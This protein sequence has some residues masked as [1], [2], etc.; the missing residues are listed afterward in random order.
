MGADEPVRVEVD[1]GLVTIV[2]DQPPIN[3][4]DA[5]VSAALL[6]AAGEIRWSTDAR[7]VVITG[8]SKVFAAGGDV[9]E[10][11]TWD[12]GRAVRESSALG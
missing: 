8:G 3:A 1:G 11:V 9:K 7:A 5:R 10:I 2:L 12:Y 4:L 6:T